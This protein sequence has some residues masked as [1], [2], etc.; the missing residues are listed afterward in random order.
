MSA[1]DDHP[2][3][4]AVV[5]PCAAGKSTLVAVLRERGYDARHVAQE[6]SYV[7]AMWR[8][9]SRPDLLIFLDVDYLTARSRRPTLDGGPQ[10]VVDQ[11]AR[12]AHAREHCDIYVDTRS[13]TP[14]EIQAHVL[15]YLAR[16]PTAQ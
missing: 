14:P 5:G 11:Q 9:I 8:R 15:T 2:V 6:H 13:L 12:L 1:T 10:R 3:R 4:I 16:W 7:P